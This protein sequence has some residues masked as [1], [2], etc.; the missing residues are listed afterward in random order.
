MTSLIPL[1]FLERKILLDDLRIGHLLHC[2]MSVHLWVFGCPR[3]NCVSSA[4]HSQPQPQYK[5]LTL[6][7]EG[8][9]P[10]L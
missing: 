1:D 2:L 7:K 4:T 8:S 9:V 10:P 5:A 6:N 3:H